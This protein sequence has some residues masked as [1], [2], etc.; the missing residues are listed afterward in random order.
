MSNKKKRIIIIGGLSA[1]PSAAAKAR[2]INEDCDIILFEK[3]G[4]ISY[5]TCG[6]PYAVSGVISQRKKL[7]VAQA[8]TFATR[9]NIDLHLGEE[10][11]G[12]TPRQKQIQTSKGTYSYDKLILATG[13]KTVIPPIKGLKEAGNWSALRTLEDF[14]K[15]MKKGGIKDANNVAVLGGGLIGVELAE[16][17][18]AMG[19]SVTLIEAGPQI[20]PQWDWEFSFHAAQVLQEKGLKL[21]E[22]TLMN[23]VSVKN[24]AITHFTTSTGLQFKTEYLMICAGIRPNTNLLISCG[25]KA[26]G[27]GALIV[28]DKM[29]TSLPHIYAA[30]DCA[31]IVNLQT[32]LQGYFPLGTHS[33]KAGRCAGAN[34]A[35]GRE[36]FKGAYGTAIIKVFD[37]SLART[38]MNERELIQYGQAAQSFIFYAPSS[39]GYYP[40]GSEQLVKVS[41]HKKSGKLL[42]AQIFGQS[43]V[44][45]R[46]DV[47]STAIYAGLTIDDLPNLDLAYAP[48]FSPAKDPVIV[49]GFVGGNVKKNHIKFI[50]SSSLNKSLKSH[51][52]IQLVDVRDKTELKKYGNIEGCINIPLD[53]LRQGLKTLNPLKDT[54][55]YCQMGLR[56][57]LAFLILKHNGFK[58]IQSLEGG[59]T[60]WRD[61]GF[62]TKLK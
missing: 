4:D 38:G 8:Q 60:C 61:L 54:V 59:F 11:T 47:F 5:A 29:H 32:G 20:L 14:D 40:G 10:V 19:K 17:L 21:I 42:G 24:G 48:P 52:P 36:L 22:A 9:F 28:N 30:G 49:A 31:S 45:K 62:S 58:K 57:Y 23:E 33:N 2:R 37:Y 1:G 44:D 7:L 51:K 16:N 25:A 34:A 18:A 6:L 13:A 27:N 43:G 15:V 39:P 53:T 50:T 3:G 26:I 55:I 12:I 56:S 35:G 46:I 41:Y